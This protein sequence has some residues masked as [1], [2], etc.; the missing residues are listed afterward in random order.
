MCQVIGNFFGGTTSIGID[1]VSNL[2][3]DN[4][5]NG[6]YIIDGWK[7]VNRKYFSGW[8]QNSYNI[9]EMLQ[10]IDEAQPK[11]E[12]LGDYL[13]AVE[14]PTEEVKLGDM[15]CFIN[16][17]GKLVKAEVVG[18]GEDK[19]VNG[20]K[21]RNMPYLNLHGDKEKGYDW[22]INNYIQTKTA[23]VLPKEREE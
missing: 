21:V 7:I 16:W 14:I 18:F 2:D 17:N 5:D 4:Y 1:V 12:R 22:N 8:E 19:I 10:V 13:K 15:V 6:T 3:T 20:T 23:R 11:E 9:E